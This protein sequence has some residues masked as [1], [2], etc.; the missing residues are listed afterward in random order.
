MAVFRQTPPVSLASIN[1]DVVNKF[2]EGKTH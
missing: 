1:Y 2:T